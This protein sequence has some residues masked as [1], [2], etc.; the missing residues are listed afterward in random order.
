MSQGDVNSKPPPMTSLQQS[1]VRFYR[2]LIRMTR[3]I[4]G[5]VLVADVPSSTDPAN[6]ELEVGAILLWLPPSRRLGDFDLITLWRSGFMGLMLP[7]HYGLTGFHRIQSIFEANIHSM[8]TKALPNLPR[9]FKPE[10]CGFIQM[11]ASNPKHKGKRYASALLKFQIEQHFAQYPDTPVILD[12][13]TTEGVRA[14]ERLGF[15][16]LGEMP[17]D[18]KTDASG[19]R[20]K[21][22]ASDELKRE[23]KDT[24]IQRVMTKLP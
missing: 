9:G 8:F 15:K 24:C 1:R 3:L 23:A 22:N 16:L 19:I 6:D 5:L 18:T 20:L 12:T 4:G 11:L 2:S 10:N 17:V 14:Y 13:T 21:S 7:W